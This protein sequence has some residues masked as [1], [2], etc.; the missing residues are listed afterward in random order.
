MSPRDR[1]PCSSVFPLV[2]AALPSRE[3]PI[4][5]AFSF[6]DGPR[7]RKADASGFRSKFPRAARPFSSSILMERS[8]P[9]SAPKPRRHALSP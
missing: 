8:A 1:F 5:V 4:C 6:P 3:A 9:T 7:R 2:I